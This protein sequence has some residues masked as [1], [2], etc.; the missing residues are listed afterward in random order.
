M[1]IKRINME[2]FWDMKKI[3]KNP[4]KGW[5]MQYYSNSINSYGSTL[6]PDDFLKDFPGL[7]HIYL[8]LAWSYLEPEEGKYDWSIIDNVIE[9]WVEQGY[10][11]AF[12]ITCTE[13]DQDQIFATPEWVRNSGASGEFYQ[14]PYGAWENWQPDYGDPV[15]LEKLENF[16]KVFASRYDGKPW[17]EYIDIGSYG[18]WGEGHTLQT[19]KKDWSFD[20]LKEH[21]DIHLRSYKNSLLMINDDYISCRAQED[22]SKE[23]LLEYFLE[24]GLA[25]RDDSICVKWHSDK[26]GL[27]TL[28]NPEIYDRFWRSRPVD[29]ELQHHPHIKKTGTWKKGWPLIA[30]VD[31]SHATFVG[32]HGYAREWLDENFE[33]AYELVNR[34]GYWYLLREIE[35]PENIERGSESVLKIQWLNRGVA[36]AYY[37]YNLYLKLE[38]ENGKSTYT[39]QLIESDNRKWIPCKINEESYCVKIPVDL[40][41]GCYKLQIA[42]VEEKENVKRNI[43]LGLKNTIRGSDNFYNIGDVEIK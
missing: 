22:G 25:V 40:A 31:E 21:V 23:K 37:K 4:H 14:C 33:L 34:M 41:A 17:V 35:I 7:N 6:A 2:E 32:F 15:F 36:P 19:S 43:E 12:R 10:S 5:Y 20:I 24:N 29:L 1:S 42:L 18:D 28:R 30:A 13:T 38:K 16:H 39:Q 8:R 3:C 26:F 9:R 11:V 27:S